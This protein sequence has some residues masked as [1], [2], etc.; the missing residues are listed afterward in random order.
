VLIQKEW[1]SFGH[2]FTSRHTP[3]LAKSKE[4]GPVFLQWLDCVWQVR[5]LNRLQSV[6]SSVG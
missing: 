3:W 5:E 1:V 6:S 4:G 2:K